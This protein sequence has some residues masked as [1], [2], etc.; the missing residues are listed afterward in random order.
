MQDFHIRNF[1]P[2]DA[3]QCC[4]LI[5]N[6]A[7]M[8]D[9]LNEAGL[10]FILS[11]NTPQIRSKEFLALYT[12][13]YEREGKILGL[14]VLDRNEIKRMYVDPSAQRQGIGSAIITALEKEA[15]TRKLKFLTIEAQPNAVPFYRKLGYHVTKEDDIKNGQATFHVFH[16]KKQLG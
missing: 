3:E 11:L 8:M 16:M 12:L 6:A 15:H 13:V 7:A 14:G 4:K 2:E 5:D 10:Q 1:T 9:G